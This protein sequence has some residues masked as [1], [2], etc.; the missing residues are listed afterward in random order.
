MPR[1]PSGHRGGR[2][3]AGQAAVFLSQHAGQ[4]TVVVRSNDLGQDMSRYLAD[5]IEGIGRIRVLVHSE[6]RAVRGRRLLEE[7]V[8]EDLK[9]GERQAVPAKAL[10]VFIGSIPQDARARAKAV[11]LVAEHRGD[12]ANEWEAINTV[13]GRLGM[14]PES[15]RRRVRQA[16]DDSGEADGGDDRAGAGDLGVEAQERRAGRDD[17]D[18][19]GGD[20]PPARPEYGQLHRRIRSWYWIH[21]RGR[22][23][24][25]CRGLA[26]GSRPTLKAL[27]TWLVTNLNT[28]TIVVLIVL[29]TVMIGQGLDLFR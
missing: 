27:E 21:V 18:P 16:A 15:P 25:H 14:T 24:L 7:V 5:R 20:K 17:Q 23:G 6:V 19:Q 4:V 11:R 10:F 22:G 12:Y 2:N 29:A 1:R 8:I 26:N 9:S 3:S 28:V 13:A